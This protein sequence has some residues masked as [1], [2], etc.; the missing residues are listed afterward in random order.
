MGRV[1]LAH[2]EIAD[3]PVAPE[4]PPNGSPRQAA[5]KILA[6]DLAQE[7]GFLRRFQR[8]I[9]AL[10]LLSHPNIVRF[11]DSGAVDGHYYYAMEYIAGR[12]FDELLRE[13]GRL[14]WKE[15][16]DLALQVCPALKQAQDH[17]TIHREIKPPNLLRTN[18]GVVK[19]T[20]FGIAKV[21][22]V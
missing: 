5:L 18:A 14:P 13:K 9:D 2:E 22:A 16:L 8:E 11:Y 19:L 4:Q 20:D 21:F 17:G 6:P 10:S 15:V 7:T 1:Y 12:N 3:A